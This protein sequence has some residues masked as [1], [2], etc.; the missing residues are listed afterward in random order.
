MVTYFSVIVAVT[1]LVCPPLRFLLQRV[2]P[3][4]GQGP[5][6]KTMTNGY[7]HLECHAV[8]SAGSKCSSS[9]YFPQV[10]G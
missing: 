2:L 6:E 4:P 9:L 5:S 1:C 7:L 3:A 8:G 10:S